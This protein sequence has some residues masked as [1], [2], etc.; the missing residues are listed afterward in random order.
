MEQRYEAEL[1]DAYTQN[2]SLQTQLNDAYTKNYSLQ[3]ELDLANG[4]LASMT[5]LP[6]QAA[7]TQVRRQE[8]RLLPP[9]STQ[10][11][12]QVPKIR[13]HSQK[14]MPSS[15]AQPVEQALPRSKNAEN[16]SS[17][18][19]QDKVAEKRKTEHEEEQKRQ[20]EGRGEF[21]R[22]SGEERQLEARTRRV[23]RERVLAGEQQNLQNVEIRMVRIKRFGGGA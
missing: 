11:S 14:L 2:H 20:I 3:E 4:K 1:D 17:K 15:R 16:R 12:Q 19:A 18:E 9:P 21:D 22:Q 6:Q 8:E 5:T 10:S 23:Q 7:Q 13:I